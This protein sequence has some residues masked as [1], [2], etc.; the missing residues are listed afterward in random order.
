MVTSHKTKVKDSELLRAYAAL[1][2]TL[3]FFPLFRRWA[4]VPGIP[5]EIWRLVERHLRRKRNCPKGTSR[6]DIWMYGH[7]AE[8]SGPAWNAGDWTQVNVL[9]ILLAAEILEDIGK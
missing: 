9:A 6:A 1:L 5:E 3:E 4:H 8:D 2:E 7:V